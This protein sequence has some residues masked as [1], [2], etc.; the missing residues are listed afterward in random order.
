VHWHN[1]RRLHGYLDDRPP[2]EYEQA[3]YAAHRDDQ[4]PVDIP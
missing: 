4:Q 2:A 3:F 1:T